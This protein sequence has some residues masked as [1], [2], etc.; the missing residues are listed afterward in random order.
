MISVGP[1]K[2]KRKRRQKKKKKSTLRS[3]GQG[4]DHSRGRRHR[5]KDGQRYTQV[6]GVYCAV[7]IKWGMSFLRSNK[8]N[9]AQRWTE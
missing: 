5:I 8:Y 3:K 7:T 9:K 4:V 2:P 1:E 6:F